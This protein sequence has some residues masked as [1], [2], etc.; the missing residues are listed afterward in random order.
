MRILTKLIWMP[1]W[2]VY[3][4]YYTMWYSFLAHFGLGWRISSFPH[5]LL[6]NAVLTIHFVHWSSC[7]PLN[8]E[9]CKTLS[10][11]SY[12]YSNAKNVSEIA[13]WP[14][15]A[16]RNSAERK[17]Q[18]GVEKCW[19]LTLLQEMSCMERILRTTCRIFMT[20][21]WTSWANSWFPISIYTVG[22]KML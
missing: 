18:N 6:C 12:F 13:R 7:P 16:S 5:W 10:I 17:W 3:R 14:R 2:M 15:G 4:F 1:I 8:Y 11:S 19:T 22:M 20:Q 9:W 21:P